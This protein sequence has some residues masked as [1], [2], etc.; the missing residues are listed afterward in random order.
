MHYNLEQG[1]FFTI[2]NGVYPHQP[3][4]PNLNLNTTLVL[5]LNLNILFIY[6][7]HLLFAALLKLNIY[8]AVRHE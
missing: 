5:N 6:L 1:F 2:I 7:S 8:S 4:K 3:E